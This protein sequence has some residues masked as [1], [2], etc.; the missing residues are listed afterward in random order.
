[1]PELRV[2]VQLPESNVKKLVKLTDG[3]GKLFDRLIAAVRSK[4]G[5]EQDIA[6]SATDADG[7]TIELDG[8]DALEMMLVGSI[9]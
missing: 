1:M 6:L 8:D 2:K 3:T 4:I 5:T 7:D 9:R